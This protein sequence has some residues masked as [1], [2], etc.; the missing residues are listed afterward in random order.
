MFSQYLIRNEIEYDEEYEY[1]END[2]ENQEL[3]ESATSENN[4]REDV[5]EEVNDLNNNDVGIKNNNSKQ[6]K[7]DSKKKGEVESD[8]KLSEENAKIEADGNDKKLT[9]DNGS[10]TATTTTTAS[11]VKFYIRI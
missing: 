11:N 2:Y 5:N 9:A 10:T 4:K 8:E 1:D 7:S 6:A 3:D